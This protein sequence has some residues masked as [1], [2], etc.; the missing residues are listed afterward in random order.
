MIY[1]KKIPAKCSTTLTLNHDAT[2]N[3][4][5]KRVNFLEVRGFHPVIFCFCLTHADIEF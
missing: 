4:C 5:A 1:K 2:F 3:N